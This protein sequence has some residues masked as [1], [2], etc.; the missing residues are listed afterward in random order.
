MMEG[1]TTKLIM[2]STKYSRGILS[3]LSNIYGGE[4]ASLQMFDRLLNTYNLCFNECVSTRKMLVEAPKTKPSAGLFVLLYWHSCFHF[5]VFRF[6]IILPATSFCLLF[7]MLPP[8]GL[9]SRFLTILNLFKL[10]GKSHTY[11]NK[12]AVL[13]AGLFNYVWLFVTT[14]DERV[15]LIILSN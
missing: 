7:T 12:P 4:T 15:N 10:D 1:V 14:R 3:S 13:T 5:S 9:G 8:T 6:L 11:L 2:S